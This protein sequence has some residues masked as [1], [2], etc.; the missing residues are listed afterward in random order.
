MVQS[1]HVFKYLYIHNS[2]D[3]AFDPCFQGVTSDQNN[4]IKFQVMKALYIDAEGE[5]PQNA[6][7]LRGKPVQVNFSSILIMQE[8][9]KIGD[10]K[11][12]LFYIAIKHQ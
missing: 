10:L 3:I 8:I 4:Q 5:I 1:L 2:N 6:P 7:N 9:D 11:R 12:G